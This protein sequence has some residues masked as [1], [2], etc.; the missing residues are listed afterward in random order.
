MALFLALLTEFL[1][2]RMQRFFLSDLVY[3]VVALIMLDLVYSLCNI[4]TGLH[5]NI[6]S[7]CYSN[8]SVCVYERS[9]LISNLL[10]IPASMTFTVATPE[11]IIQ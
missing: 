7:G 2:D 8:P 6:S 11:V 10:Y 3:T 5:K 4:V 9:K 1:I